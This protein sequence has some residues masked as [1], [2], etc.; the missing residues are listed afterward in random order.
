MLLFLGNHEIIREP[1]KVKGREGERFAGAAHMRGVP[2]G[3]L[4]LTLSDLAT[5]R[6]RCDR[7]SFASV[8]CTPLTWE[9]CFGGDRKG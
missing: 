7:S 6:A 1:E 2:L 9:G 8:S 4:S 5:Q 3:H